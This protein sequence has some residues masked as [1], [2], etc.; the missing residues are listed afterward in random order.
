MTDHRRVS[1]D[2]TTSA[3]PVT[4]AQLR[5]DPDL[6]MAGI[7]PEA[8]DETVGAHDGSATAGQPGFSTSEGAGGDVDTDVS[9]GRISSGADVAARGGAPVHQEQRS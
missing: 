3:D 5:A 8:M 2:P 7:D 9:E 1:A 4:A 6:V